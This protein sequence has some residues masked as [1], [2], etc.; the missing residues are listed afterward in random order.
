MATT[1]WTRRFTAGL[2]ATAVALL[3]A[4]AL[5]GAAGATTT[6]GG[7]A[8]AVTATPTPGGTATSTPVDPATCSADFFSADPRLGPATLPTRG[9]VGY[10]LLGYHRTG[11]LTPAAFLSSYYDP[12]LYGGTGGWIYPPDNGYQLRPNGTPIE[13]QKTRR[14]GRTLDRFGSEYGAFLSPAGSPYASRAIPPS[15][16]DST[17]AAGC[18]YHEYQVLKSFG[19]EAG[20]I[21]AWFGQPGG[22]WQYQLEPALVSGAPTPLTVLW[23]VD[24]GYLKRLV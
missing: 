16:L 21:A 17:P 1:L 5:A 24:N 10:E 8:P 13:W 14:P 4:T 20:P 6:T 2:T 7:A 18:N 12:T 3:A 22:G 15:N 19:A 11:S 23:L 9:R